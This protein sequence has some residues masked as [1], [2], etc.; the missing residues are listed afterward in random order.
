[1]DLATRLRRRAWR[2]RLFSSPVIGV[3]PIAVTASIALGANAAGNENKPLG[4]HLVGRQDD[5]SVLTA[6][7]AY[8]TPAG[9]SI[10]QTGRPMDLEVSP[11]GR[12]ATAL[13]K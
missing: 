11:D 6:V 13:T 9:D 8:V 10:E 7:N 5:G 12:T 2:R 3:A 1:M 4:E